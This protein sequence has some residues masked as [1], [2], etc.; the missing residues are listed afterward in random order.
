MLRFLRT[1]MAKWPELP[2]EDIQKRARILVID[3]S[4]FFYLGLFKK[5]G[6]LQSER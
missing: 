3:D 1:W 5:D 6:Y 2:L 4:E